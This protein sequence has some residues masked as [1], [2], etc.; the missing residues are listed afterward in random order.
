MAASTLMILYASWRYALVPLTHTIFEYGRYL[1]GEV[2]LGPAHKHVNKGKS[3]G[4]FSIA[5]D[6]KARADILKP[7]KLLKENAKKLNDRVELLRGYSSAGD[8]GSHLKTAEKRRDAIKN[9]VPIWFDRNKESRDSK[10]RQKL[11]NEVSND[12]SASRI[13]KGK[14]YEADDGSTLTSEHFQ[15][16]KIERQFDSSDNESS[17]HT[18]Y[19]DNLVR[20]IQQQLEIPSKS[21]QRTLS[22]LKDDL[23]NSQNSCPKDGISSILEINVTLV[24]QCSMDRIWLLSQTC[25]RWSNPM[26]LVVCLPSTSVSDDIKRS[27]VADSIA[28]IMV[29]CPQMTVIPHVHDESDSTYPVNTMRNI[30]LDAVA[31]SHILIMDVDLIPSVDLG[32][33]VID[34]LVDQ[35]TMHNNKSHKKSQGLQI[36]MEAIVVPAFERTVDSPCN[37]IEDCKSYMQNDSKFLPSLFTDLKECVDN[38]DCIVFQ[39]D[40]NWEGHHTTNSKKWLKKEWYEADSS[41][42]KSKA[43]RI[44]QIKCFDSLRYGKSYSEWLLCLIISYLR[45]H[46]STFCLAEEPYVVLPWCPPIKSVHPQPL[47]P[48]YDERFYGYGKN[49]I[50]HI[51][52]L[53]YRGVKFS[54]IPQSF[55]VHHPHPESNVKQVWNNKKENK[56][57]GT[58]DKLYLKYITELEGV[59]DSDDIQVVPQCSK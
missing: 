6:N 8:G 24:I 33:V 18:Q 36:P 15:D 56:L 41:G 46:S 12:K 25:L 16:K 26:V 30:G 34:N 23:D 55:A 42:N 22:T 52:H 7:M 2:T 14:E 17:K 9:I 43:R 51:S 29:H 28:E 31:T 1:S 48:Y 11:K 13:A 39:S 4:S 47:T 54:V 40:T 37:S 45:T 5:D 50:Q 20:Q 57:H 49:K 58:M 38:K 19:H 27:A 35:I 44:R 3:T 53:R 32:Q 21:S 10:S 59:Y